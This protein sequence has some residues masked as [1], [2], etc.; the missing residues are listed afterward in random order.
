MLVYAV[1]PAGGVPRHARG[2]AGERLSSVSAG[3][4][5]AVVGEVTRAPQASAASLRRYDRVV[6]TLWSGCPSLLPARFGTRFETVEELRQVL[7]SRRDRLARD[8]RRVRGR[9]QMNLR[10]LGLPDIEET[11]RP[12]RRAASG[13]A[14][15]H[16]R[17]A[18]ALRQRRVP[19]FDAVRAEVERFVRGEEVEKWKRG[20][21]V[22]HLVP[23]A[24]AGVYQRT[25]ERAAA[26]AGLRVV[27]TGPH[28]PYAFT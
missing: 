3:R 27:V 28:P 10:I 2:V 16:G 7:Y 5:R 18:D 14:Y 11:V 24:S 4:V 25:L 6:R 22:Y 17:A 12:R 9:A 13:T 8:L 26:A 20:A 19:G 21:T 1:T 23:R 15:L